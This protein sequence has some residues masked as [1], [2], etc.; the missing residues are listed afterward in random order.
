MNSPSNTQPS[1]QIK[2]GHLLLFCFIYFVLFAISNPSGNPLAS[3]IF[4]PLHKLWQMII[5]FVG[6]NL[7]GI[8][9]TFPL[10]R[11]GSSDRTYNY[12]QIFCIAI[13]ALIGSF[14][15]S[16]FARKRTNIPQLQAWFIV[17]VRY[18]LICLL[19][20]YGIIKIFNSQFPF[21]RLHH[22]L[23]PLGQFS[24]MGLFWNTMGYSSSYTIFSGLSEIL[25]GILLCFRRTTTL[26]ALVTIGVTS[27]I[28]MIN[29]SY[30]IPVK[31][32]STH[33]LLFATFLLIPDL[34]RV[35]NVFVGNKPTPPSN[36]PTLPI[37]ERWDRSRLLLKILFIGYISITN[38]NYA[39][40]GYKQFGSARPKPALYGIYD[41]EQFTSNTVNHPPLTTDTKRWKRI[42]M[43]YPES[44]TIQFMDDK[45]K[46]YGFQP[47][48]SA[49]TITMY[50]YPDSTHKFELNYDTPTPKELHITG[51][52]YKD[53]LRVKLKQY[54]LQKFHLIN[55]GFNWI[56]EHPYNR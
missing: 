19:F 53:T 55:R 12:L 40:G 56:Q 51:L 6:T 32:L 41:V 22:L 34:R 5:P 2:F 25:A 18:Y 52:F 45:M 10:H 13:I 43:D 47:D 33:L 4:L 46:W 8:D 15:W 17:L 30:D 48:T 14:A 21:P 9:Y 24:P 29:F 42:I 3:Y 44:I 35:I 26:G 20:Q 49:Q 11:T 31:V 16:F 37:P 38:I 36:L 28:V 39:Y 7:F 1:E 50:T 23:Q 54:D 27:N